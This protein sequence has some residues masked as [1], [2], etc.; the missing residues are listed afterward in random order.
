MHW[1]GKVPRCVPGIP[2]KVAWRCYPKAP[3]V[4]YGRIICWD[5]FYNGLESKHFFTA[6]CMSACEFQ[7]KL[8]FHVFL[9]RL[10]ELGL[11]IMKNYFLA[12]AN[13]SFR[14]KN[15][16]NWKDVIFLKNSY[17]SKCAEFSISFFFLASEN[18][19]FRFSVKN[20]VDWYTFSHFWLIL[21]FQ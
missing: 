15:T 21:L 11:L 14:S 7:V 18:N 8:F 19:I 2:V 4:N 3:D 5:S 13:A 9:N 1:Q 6:W 12:P 20:W 16:N 10:I 17:F